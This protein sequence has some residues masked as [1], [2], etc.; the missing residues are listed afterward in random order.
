MILESGEVTVVCLVSGLKTEIIVL[1]KEDLAATQREPRPKDVAVN[2]G[3]SRN[4]Y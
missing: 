3:F 1:S 2:P 4:V